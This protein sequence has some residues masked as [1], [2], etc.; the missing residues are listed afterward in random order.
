MTADWEVRGLETEDTIV[1]FDTP[2]GRVGVEASNR[3]CLYAPRFG[4]VRQVVASSNY[5]QIDR[6]GHLYRPIEAGTGKD[7][8][9]PIVN[10]LPEQPIAA[11][12]TDQLALLA[13]KDVQTIASQKVRAIEAANGFQAHEDFLLIR[14]GIY[15]Q[16]EK[17]R[18]AE[19]IDAATV[20]ATTQ[21]V[22]IFVE[23]HPAQV[24]TGDRRAQA[25]YS[26]DTPD[27]SR[28]HVC[29]VASKFG[30]KP[31]EIVDFTIRFDNIG[32][33]PLGNVTIVDN[34]TTRLELVPKSDQSSLKADFS[35][36]P[37]AA[38]SLV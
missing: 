38:G 3:I 33:T 23:G 17:A 12:T 22:E 36:L 28:L 19:W 31:G 16:S 11:L 5:H 30:A 34:L 37:I 20:W 8:R 35:T 6:L 21:G 25:T 24:E 18:M 14:Y 15:A 9:P 4:A 2:D 7:V 10:V 1:H 26:V 32:A 13:S 29:K 27:Y